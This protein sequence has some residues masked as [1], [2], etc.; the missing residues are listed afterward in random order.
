MQQHGK[1]NGT[2]ATL[3]RT[4]GSRSRNARSDLY[5]A[6]DLGTNSCRMLVAVPDGSKIRVIDSFSKPVRLGLD[7]ERDGQLSEPAVAR[8]IRALQV[9]AS[10]L[11]RHGVR[12]ARHVATEACRRATNGPALL[13]RVEAE[14]GLK[15]ELIRPE[16]EARLAVIS[17]APLIEPSTRQVLVIDIGG[18]STELVWIDVSAAAPKDR[19]RSVMTLVPRAAKA[20]NGHGS[21]GHAPNGHP[22]NGHP[23]N[24]H[25]PNGNGVP[26]GAKIVDWISVP[27]GVATLHQR[28]SDVED[29]RA[30]FALMSW[31][32]EEH[33]E[34]FTPYIQAET[35]NLLDGLQMIGTSGTVTT[36]GAAHLGLRKYERDRV[37]GMWMTEEEV[38]LVIEAFL[39][40]GRDGRVRY[41]GLGP[42]R[43]DLS[44]SGAAI[45][46]TLLRAWPSQKLRVA[47]RGLR[48]GL[49][50]SMMGADGVL[51]AERA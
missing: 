5:A 33:L 39:R 15:L 34:E 3:P 11:R 16:E 32:F 36:I 30:R 40:L 48:E 4:R 23:S 28:F 47:D 8:T 7:I 50:Y 19:A 45:L 31:Y 27:L 20:L 38:N 37:D 44:L 35:A 17:C 29:D 25:G 43:A 18:G 42:E 10:K 12:R 13:R 1:L 6:V 24:G 49:L 2:P 22:P 26:A 51:G 14:T 41:P 46:Q 9:C 21:N